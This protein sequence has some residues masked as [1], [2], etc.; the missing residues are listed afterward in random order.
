MKRILLAAIVLSGLGVVGASQAEDKPL[1]LGVIEPTPVHYYG[2]HATEPQRIRVMFEKTGGQWAVLP[3]TMTDTDSLGR[4]TDSYPPEMNWTIAFNGR[5]RGHVHSKRLD[6]FEYFD[7]VGYQRPDPKAS[8]PKITTDADAFQGGNGVPAF[9]PLVVVSDPNVE[10]P[11]HWKP[12]RLTRAEEKR[13]IAEFRKKIGPISFDCSV[14]TT[15]IY[16]DK[17]ILTRKSY[18]STAGDELAALQLDPS[19][20]QCD[21]PAGDLWDVQWFHVK[22]S[23]VSWIDQDLALVDAGD[24]DKDGHSEVLFQKSGYNY[25]GYVLLCDQLTHQL[26]FGWHYH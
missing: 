18:Q 15:E 5:A 12:F 10:D 9:R 11:D 14:V 21:G 17:L 13:L 19:K 3:S 16:E 23:T 24:Y 2:E 20:N 1:Y 25:G 7:E 4:L 8:I 22:G 26:E 6:P